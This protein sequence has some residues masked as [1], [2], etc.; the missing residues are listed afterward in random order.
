[1]EN[2]ICSQ[3]LLKKAKVRDEKYIFQLMCACSFLYIILMYLLRSIAFYSPRT[4]CLCNRNKHYVQLTI[5]LCDLDIS[6]ISTNNI[7]LG[8][9]FWRMRKGVMDSDILGV[10]VFGRDRPTQWPLCRKWVAHHQ[11]GWAMTRD[12]LTNR[13]D[14]IKRSISGDIGCT[15]FI[16]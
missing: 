7:R 5:R 11:W 12:H 4:M 2:E 9:I 15:L 1:M 10:S 14:I 6:K 16:E 8:S 13:K 3:T